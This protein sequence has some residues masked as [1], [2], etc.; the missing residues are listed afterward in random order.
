MRHRDFADDLLA[1]RIP[2]FVH[3]GRHHHLD[4][5][6]DLWAVRAKQIVEFDPPAGDDDHIFL[7]TAH[8]LVDEAKPAVAD[9]EPR[10]RP[11]H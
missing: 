5:D 7:F 8:C 6:G 4:D 11:T 9:I 10:E 2:A 1:V 3:A